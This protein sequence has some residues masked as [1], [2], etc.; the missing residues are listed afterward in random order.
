MA[1]LQDEGLSRE[2]QLI[3]A[4]LNHIFEPEGLQLH[5][6]SDAQCLQVLSLV[7]ISEDV[8]H[9]EGVLVASATHAL[10]SLDFGQVYDEVFIVL[11]VGVIVV[12]VQF[13]RASLHNA[14]GLL[15]STLLLVWYHSFL[16]LGEDGQQL[17]GRSLDVADRLL[18]LVD[19][20]E[21][22][23]AVHRLVHGA[24]RQVSEVLPQTRLPSP[25]QA[26]I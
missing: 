22:A 5:D 16:D 21:A 12:A 18:E 9:V 25:S 24:T 1:N 17:L 23:E 15:F 3:L 6:I 8:L 11:P 13:L 20:A 10:A 26:L 2:L 14:L 19:G 4:L 7:Q